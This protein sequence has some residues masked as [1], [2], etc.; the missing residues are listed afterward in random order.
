M[1]ITNEEI[2]VGLINNM[3]KSL[4]VVGNFV[5]GRCVDMGSEESAI[6]DDHLRVLGNVFDSTDSLAILLGIDLSKIKTIE[7]IMSELT[8]AINNLIH[9]NVDITKYPKH[10]QEA[11]KNLREKMPSPISRAKSSEED[12]KLRKEIEELNRM[13]GDDFKGPIN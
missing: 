7:E 10:A 9:S 8:D 1:A 3:R 6:A 2:V 11:I 4:F 12:E 13:L 5:K